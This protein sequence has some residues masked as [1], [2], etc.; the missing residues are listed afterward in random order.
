MNASRLLLTGEFGQKVVALHHPATLCKRLTY[1]SCSLLCSCLL[2]LCI[3][4]YHN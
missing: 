2:P 3:I 1:Y 4:L